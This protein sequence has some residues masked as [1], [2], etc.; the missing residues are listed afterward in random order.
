MKNDLEQLLPFVSKASRYLGNEI[1][2]VKKDPEAIDLTFAF[3]FPDV[4]EVGMSHLGLQILYH[5]LNSMPGIACERAFAPW[6]DDM[7]AEMKAAGLP[8]ATLESGIPLRQCGIV[9]FSLEYELCYATVLRMLDLSG[10]PLKAAERDSSWP[11]VI[12][13]GPSTCNPE[14]VADF[15]D[16]FVIGEGEEVLPELCRA[17]L[18]WKQSGEDKNS[19]LEALAGIAGI[20]VPSFFSITYNDNGTIRQITPLKKGCDHVDK[21]IITG[22]SHAPWC[23]KPVVPYMQIIHDRAGIEIARGCTRG[24]RFCMAGMIYRPVREK[25]VDRL[26]ELSRETLSGSGYEELGLLSLS[27][28]DYSG[29][30][31]LL[32]ALMREHRSKKIAM[33]L[34]SLRVESL[35]AELIEEIRQIRKTGFTIAP[36]AGTQRLRDAINKGFT[37]TDILSTATRIFAAGWNLVKLYFMIGLP[38]ETTQDI[39]GIVE[40]CRAL[41]RLDRRKNINVSISTFVPKPHTPFQWE[42]F[43]PAGSIVEKQQYLKDSLRSRTVKVTYHDHRL[44]LLEAVFSRGDRRLADVLVQAHSLGAG[45]DAWSE[46]FDHLLWDQAFKKAGI[47]TAFYLKER[48]TD[49]ILPW[50]HIS[51]GVTKAY[52]LNEREKA[53]RG[54]MT[55]DCR[56]GQCSGCGVCDGTDVKPELYPAGPQTAPHAARGMI[57]E[58]DPFRYRLA[59]TKEGAARFISHLEFSSSFARA[60]RRAGLPLRY[61]QGFHPLPRVTFHEALPVGLECSY[62]LCDIELTEPVPAGDI[63]HKL[64]RELP[65]GITI[66]TVEEN[67]LKSAPAPD[68]IKKY[69]VLFPENSGLHFPGTDGLDRSIAGFH[70]RGSCL[71]QVEK[72]DRSVEVDLKKIIMDLALDADGKILM[73]LDAAGHSMPKIPAIMAVLFG[74]GAREQ[75]SLRI[76]K[77]KS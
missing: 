22:F 58:P 17:Y 7:E 69:R 48:S 35:T 18:R 57:P 37:D 45:Y 47:D 41:G 43:E 30:Q 20:Y 71:M 14:P 19:L 63:R 59:Y 66:L 46:H 27:S 16:A 33:S 24:C 40:L 28:G 2:A 5:V 13:G 52:L 1:N 73:T 34:P 60:L 21:R 75:K 72:K 68:T 6:P 15:F 25:S 39:E 65:D 31:P 51:Y 49:E 67:I 70:A 4:Y 9:G 8:L 23:A 53:R 50:D 56:H 74:L 38:T 55:P 77:M 32:G 29:I 44:S 76:T 26:C 12:A 10:I 54:E 36:E 64:N 11:L 3:A 61:S 62:A 42:A